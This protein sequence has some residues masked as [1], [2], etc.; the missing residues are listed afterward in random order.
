[1]TVKPAVVLERL[2]HLGFV[3]DQLERLRG[4]PRQDPVFV[5]ALERGLQVAAETIFDIGHHV[6]AGRGRPVP[7]KYRD[8]LPALV[9][10]GVL[11][12]GIA[13]RL[14]GLAGLRNL[15]VHDYGIV[16]AARLWELVDSRLD[17]LRAVHEALARLPELGPCRGQ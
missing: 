17:D 13:E 3:I 2:A 1:V 15:L 5:L 4:L 7:P 6:L 8:V 9:T 10:D 11:T 12:K 14:D 16:D